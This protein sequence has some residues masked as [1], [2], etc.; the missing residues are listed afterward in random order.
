[1][2]NKQLFL[3]FLRHNV[4]IAS[5]N[6]VKSN[7]KFVIRQFEA[8][9]KD[10]YMLSNEQHVRNYYQLKIYLDA[11]SKSRAQILGYRYAYRN[12]LEFL[13]C[14]PEHI[15]RKSFGSLNIDLKEEATTPT[16]DEEFE[17]IMAKKPF[18]NCKIEK[19]PSGKI[20]IEL[21]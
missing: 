12:Y 10:F 21:Y 19:D 18:V 4:K 8:S 1:M 5:I 13:G 6:N 9:E 3:D 7:L 15:F 17:L 16:S 2:K 20:T 11:S 14:N